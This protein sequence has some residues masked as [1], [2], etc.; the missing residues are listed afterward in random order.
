[1]V[2]VPLSQ[3]PPHEPVG[4]VIPSS[5]NK[6]FEL[7]LPFIRRVPVHAKIFHNVKQAKFQH[8]IP[9]KFQFPQHNITFQ[10]NLISWQFFVPQSS[11]AG[12]SELPSL[13][14]FPRPVNA[15][16]FQRNKAPE[17]KNDCFPRIPA[18]RSATH[19]QGSAAPRAGPRGSGG[20]WPVAFQAR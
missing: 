5:S 14:E 10:G 16:A 2:Y 15:P 9:H 7:R 18:S 6:N 12:S 13:G 11:L 17:A 3:A 19:I 20:S 1:M 4:P 8:S